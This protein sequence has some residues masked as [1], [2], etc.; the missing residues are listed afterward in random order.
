MQN[1][2]LNSTVYVRLNKDCK[3]AFN[4]LPILDLAHFLN[5]FLPIFAMFFCFL[6]PNQH[7][8]CCLDPRS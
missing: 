4:L 5:L 1:G 3:G 7:F 2:T 6:R 8:L